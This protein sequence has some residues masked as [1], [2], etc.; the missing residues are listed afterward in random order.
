MIRVIIRSG[1]FIPLI[2]FENYQAH[3]KDYRNKKN[4]MPIKLFVI[5]E[6]IPVL[7]VLAIRF[8][9]F[10]IVCAIFFDIS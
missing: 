2:N 7:T 10:H 8:L 4:I 6:S 9:C 1:S 5:I 3:K